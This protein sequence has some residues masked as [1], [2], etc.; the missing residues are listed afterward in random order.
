MSIADV[1]RRLGLPEV[2]EGK[3]FPSPFRE[4]RHA[5]AQLGGPKNIFF[6]HAT[7][8]SLDAIALVRKWKAC[9]FSEAVQFILGNG[10]GEP[11]AAPGTPAR[12]NTRSASGNGGGGRVAKFWPDL[13]AA[14]A[15]FERLPL[16]FRDEETLRL[17]WDSYALSCFEIPPDWRALEYHGKRGVVY[18]GVGPD[19]GLVAYKWKGVERDPKNGKRPCAFLAGSGGAIM[20]DGAPGAALVLAGGEEKG[21][22][23]AVAGFHAVSFLTGERCPD[24]AWIKAILEDRDGA[25]ICA[26]DADPAGQKANTETA[27]ALMA[28]GCDA[29]R[30]RIVQWPDGAA[31]GYDLNDHLKAHGVEGLRALLE[32]APAIED[33]LPRCL[34]ARDFLAVPREVLA[35]HIDGILPYGGK[36]TFSATSKFGKSMWAIQTGLALAAGNCEWLGWQ[37]GPP[38]RT[39]Y[40]QAEIMDPLLSSRLAAIIRQMPA[41]IDRD[42]AVDNFII[43]EIATQRPNLLDPKGRGIAEALIER[44]R[45]NVLILDPLAAICPGMEENAAESMSLVLDYFSEL[46]RRFG[47]AIILVHHHGKSGVSRGSSVFEAW[48]E[49]DLAASFLEPEDH[50]VAK[51]EMRLRCVFNRGP[52]YWRTPSED[53]LWFA[54]MAEDWQPEKRGPKP[55]AGAKQVE[56]VLRAEAKPLSHNNLM[57]AVA[58]FCQCSERTAKRAIAEA[59]DAGKAREENG[60]YVLG[61]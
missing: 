52:V 46:T 18:P 58:D 51:V 39:L 34:S 12:T 41:Q 1:W 25:V 23:A 36:M 59:K 24:D 14:A 60:C 17:M 27:A 48:P 6:D 54:P 55:K 49:S 40:M 5:S 38:C 22:A 3:A 11:V 33:R 26:N 37:F 31:L 30:I 21:T 8:E 42:R 7:N 61:S 29:G 19:D 35:Y 50:T 4:D 13:V 32:A 28:A 16:A 47:L 10:S 15:E 2:P 53:S 44:H 43:Q 45:P 57:R 9:G 56:M 20:L